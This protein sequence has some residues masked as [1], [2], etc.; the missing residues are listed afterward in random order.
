[1]TLTKKQWIPII[2]IPFIIYGFFSKEQNLLDST[3][4]PTVISNAIWQTAWS[5]FLISVICN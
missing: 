1:M 2:G 5:V 4:P 3:Y